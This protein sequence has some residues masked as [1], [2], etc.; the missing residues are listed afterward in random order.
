MIYEFALGQPCIAPYPHEHIHASMHRLR[1]MLY[2]QRVDW[3]VPEHRGMEFDE[4]DTLRARYLVGMDGSGKVVCQTRMITCDHPYML[5][6][7]WPDLATERALPRTADTAEGSRSGL[8]VTLPVDQQRRWYGELQIANVE[9]ALHYGVER[10]NF[11]TYEQVAK[12]SLEKAGLPVRYYGPAKPFP[13]GE[14]FA[15]YFPVSEGL[16]AQLRKIHGISS[17]IFV[18]LDAADR[19]MAGISHVA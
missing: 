8:D 6:E 18:P 12:G 9:W 14:F 7:L 11:V 3:D 10:L 15:G 16:V 1:H 17:E 13:D 5:A 4:F 19:G 2:R